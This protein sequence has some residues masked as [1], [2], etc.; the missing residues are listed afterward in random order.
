MKIV[1]VCQTQ[2][3]LLVFYFIAEYA[4]LKQ[5]LIN[6][7]KPHF[8]KCSPDSF[9]WFKKGW[10]N[11]F[12]GG[13]CGTRFGVFAFLPLTMQ[14]SP[15]QKV[16]KSHMYLFQIRSRLKDYTPAGSQ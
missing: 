7:I 13:G 9:N 3:F 4:Y 16:V 5:L 1:H 15:F 14:I 10:K 11:T 6:N 8:I 2:S 12:M